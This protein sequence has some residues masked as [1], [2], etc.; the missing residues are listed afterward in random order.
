MNKFGRNHVLE[1]LVGH[2]RRTDDRPHRKVPLGVE[3]DVP[4]QKGL[5][6]V[7][8]AD[9]DNHRAFLG[10]DVTPLLNHFDVEFPQLE[11]H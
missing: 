2:F 10:V 5:A 6:R 9:D 11:V 8:L 3:Q 7:L 1:E 4:N